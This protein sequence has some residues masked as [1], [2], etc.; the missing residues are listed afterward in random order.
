MPKY[1]HEDHPDFKCM[2][3]AKMRDGLPDYRYFDMN[4]NDVTNTIPEEQ[5]KANRFEHHALIYTDG[6]IAITLHEYCYAMWYAI[7]GHV[8]EGCLWK[9]DEWILTDE[10]LEKLKNYVS[11]TS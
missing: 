3:V 11:K 2:L 1:P 5:I 4:G 10:S 8:L 7:D 9:K 6:S